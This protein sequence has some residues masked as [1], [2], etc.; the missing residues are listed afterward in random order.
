MSHVFLPSCYS[1]VIAYRPDAFPSLGDPDR[2]R[3]GAPRRWHKATPPGNPDNA[4]L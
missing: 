2:S 3:L 4:A 1:T